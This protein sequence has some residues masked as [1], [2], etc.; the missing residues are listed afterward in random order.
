MEENKQRKNEQQVG[1][2]N[3]TLNTPGSK[4]SDYGNVEGGS[5][6]EDARSHRD[7]DKADRSNVEPLRGKDETLGTP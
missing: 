6:T 5:A 2:Q 1:E 7:T 3:P 4:A